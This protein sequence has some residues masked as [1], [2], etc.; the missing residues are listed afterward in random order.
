MVSK[1]IVGRRFQICSIKK[2]LYK[3]TEED[4]YAN[5]YLTCPIHCIAWGFTECSDL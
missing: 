5:M 4:A 2:N 3:Q 1:E